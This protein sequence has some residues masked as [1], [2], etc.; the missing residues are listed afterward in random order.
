MIKKKKQYLTIKLF[1][2]FNKFY[3]IK[4]NKIGLCKVFV[5]S[6]LKWFSHV[7]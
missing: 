2:A 7:H 1:Y 6:W 5:F 3:Y 4:K